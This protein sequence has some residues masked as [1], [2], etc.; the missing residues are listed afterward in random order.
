[1]AGY[2][3]KPFGLRQVRLVYSSTVVDLPAAQELSFKERIASDE[4]KGND[5]IVDAVSISEAAEF[6]IS[7]GGISLEAY[8]VLTGRSAVEA[9]S[10]PNRT[11]SR[12]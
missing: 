7:D 9:G 12:C 5:K 1:M 3:D 4:L 11:M 6:E 10:T 2:G 8:A